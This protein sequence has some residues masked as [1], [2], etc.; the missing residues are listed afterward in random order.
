MPTMQMAVRT[1]MYATASAVIAG[2]DA[3]AESQPNKRYV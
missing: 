1:T 3:A 2:F